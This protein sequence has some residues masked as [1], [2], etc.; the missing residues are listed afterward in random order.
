MTSKLR[1]YWLAGFLDLKNFASFIVP[2]FRAGAV[3][4]FS[5]VA[6]GTLGKRAGG[7][8]VVGAAGAGACFGMS[9]FWIGHSDSF[10][11]Y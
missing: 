4:K 8:S 9:S 5:L 3:W 6:V 7:E 1:L 11:F 2:A 10:V